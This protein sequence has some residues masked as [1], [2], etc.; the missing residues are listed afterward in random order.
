MRERFMPK[1][2]ND[3]S[4]IS[5]RRELRRRSTPAEEKFWKIIRQTELGV[6]IRRQVSMG[7]Y[8][9]DFYIPAIRLIIELDGDSHFDKEGIAHDRERDRF[10]REQGFRVLHF[11]N[12][13]IRDS[14]DEAAAIVRRLCSRLST[15]PTPHLA[16]P[17][18]GEGSESQQTK[19]PEL[20]Q[21]APKKFF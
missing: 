21:S 3:R 14:L 10:L 18:R 2:I 9:V 1:L 16:S 12:A 20:K 6:R 17:Q 5:V 13:E 4:R 11:T 15:H 7:P 19:T 8:I